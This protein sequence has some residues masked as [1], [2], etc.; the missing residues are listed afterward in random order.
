MEANLRRPLGLTR[1]HDSL[2]VNLLRIEGRCLKGPPIL[3]TE[4]AGIF[5][6]GKRSPQSRR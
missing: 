6:F 3:M 4:S 1:D 5:N 2:H